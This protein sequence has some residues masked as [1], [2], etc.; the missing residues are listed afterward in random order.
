MCSCSQLESSLSRSLIIENILDD[1]PQLIN[2]VKRSLNVNKFFHIPQEEVT[3]RAIVLSRHYQAR[4]QDLGKEVT[5][6]GVSNILQISGRRSPLVFHTGWRRVR[7]YILYRPPTDT[8]PKQS[9]VVC[10]MC[11][12]YPGSVELVCSSTAGSR[13]GLLS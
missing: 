8:A 2:V 3:R 7:R 13:V 11:L 4:I 9:C 5:A 10:I 1:L 6:P 12:H